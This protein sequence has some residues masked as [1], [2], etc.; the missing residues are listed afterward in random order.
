MVETARSIPDGW[1]DVERPGTH[2]SPTPSLD[3]I[4]APWRPHW[5]EY[6]I[7]AALLGM[8]MVS[9]C[10]FGA[11]LEHPDSPLRRALPNGDLRRVLMG[12]A[13]GATAIAMIYSPWGKRS[14]AHFNPATTLTFLR[15]GKVPGRD[16][17]FYI[18]AQFA[19]AVAGVLLMAAAFRPWVA[20]PAVH[21]VTTT[22]GMRGAGAA[23][24][25]EAVITFVLM[26]AEAEFCRLLDPDFRLGYSPH[27]T[28]KSHFTEQEGVGLNGFVE[29]A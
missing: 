3:P 25:A 8:F 1:T 15:L 18:V 9:A 5:P 27:L 7:E 11:L 26:A 19:G 10:A 4:P 21:Y 2:P 16:A 12:C 24:G 13:M 6:G 29:M 17:A 14:G 23:F 20:N 22:P 28:G